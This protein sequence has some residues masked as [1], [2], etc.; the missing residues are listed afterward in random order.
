MG[1]GDG[2]DDGPQ[3]ATRSLDL[4]GRRVSGR[5]QGQHPVAGVSWYEAD[6]YARFVGKSLPT[7]LHWNRAATV[8]NSALIIPVSNFGGQGT[9]DVGG[10][11]DMS[12][13]G[14]Y[15]MAGNVREWC[16]QRIR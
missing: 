10:G 12:G 7:V 11:D 4:G 1:G 15:D 16:A 8:R 6:A 13:F 5:D 14:T 9:R 2:T 3:R